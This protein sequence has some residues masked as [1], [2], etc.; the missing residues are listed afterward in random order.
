MIRELDRAA[1][2]MPGE[3][4]SA[5]QPKTDE[6]PPPRATSASLVKKVDRAKLEERKKELQPKAKPTVDRVAEN[7]PKVEKAASQ[8]KQQVEKPPEAGPGAEGKE[9]GAK[10]AGKEGGKKGAADLA[11]SAADLAQQAFAHADEQVMPDKPGP[12][13]PPP[14]VIPMDAAGKPLAPDP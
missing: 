6:Q 7:K 8:V 3:T 11:A 2:R 13:A 1:G 10:A 5:T 9:K 12:V 4:E 14:P